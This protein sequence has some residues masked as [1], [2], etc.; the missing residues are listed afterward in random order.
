[1]Q[2]PINDE[3]LERQYDEAV[4]RGNERLQR[5]PRALSARYDK[6]GKRM[7]VELTNGCVFMFPPDLA[8]GLRD[9]APEDLA[10]V[11]VMPYGLALRWPLLN[12]DLTIAGL[13]TGIFG[14][15]AWM[16]ELGRKGGSRT[17][18]AK[19]TASRENGRQGGRPHTEK[20][21]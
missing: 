21:A 12:A 14:T 18:E 3:E 17:S 11:E 9:A 13:L 20:R 1:M 7:V 10:Q 6:R 5:E 19:A 16:S 4:Q 15:K 8:Q 2:L